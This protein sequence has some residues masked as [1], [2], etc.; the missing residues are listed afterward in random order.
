MICDGTV[1]E[2]KE[3]SRSVIGVRSVIGKGTI[4]RSSILMGNKT[5]AQV[6][7]A[8]TPYQI[9]ENCLIEKA[10]I[11]QNVRIGDHVKL[12]NYQNLQTFDG[13]GIYIRDGIM[14]VAANTSIP[15]GFT[16]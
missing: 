5:F 10:I 16:F 12:V 8:A 3:V 14:I 1:I 7:D 4:V 13:E 11:D 9:G 15:D 6:D 2:A